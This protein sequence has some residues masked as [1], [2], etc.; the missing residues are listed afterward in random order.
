M[1]EGVYE[2]NVLISTPPLVV[3]FVKWNDEDRVVLGYGYG[4]Y[5]AHFAKWVKHVEN[6][7]LEYVHDNWGAIFG[8]KFKPD[9]IYERSKTMVKDDNTLALSNK[10]QWPFTEGFE[11]FG[12]GPDTRDIAGALGAGDLVQVRFV[13]EGTYAMEKLGIKLKMLGIKLLQK[14]AVDMNSVRE[15][16]LAFPEFKLDA[17]PVS[18]YTS[19][20]EG[21]CKVE[22]SGAQDSDCSQDSD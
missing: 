3:T 12:L 6:T 22:E 13:V 15:D 16:G 21:S 9:T 4:Q 5:A 14:A 11:S 17:G 20:S 10:Y 1:K 18:T 8:K 19:D 2:S 7:M